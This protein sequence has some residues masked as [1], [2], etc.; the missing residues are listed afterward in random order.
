MERDT[1]PYKSK[2]Q[3]FLLEH[4]TGSKY[5]YA[6]ELQEIIADQVEIGRDANCQVRFDE[7]FETVSRHHA[8]IVR[9]GNHWKLVPLSQTNP[10]FL[11]GEI[12]QKEWY[13]QDGDEIQC[14]VNG[15]KLV[16]KL[17]ENVQLMENVTE[18]VTIQKERH[19]CVTAW[20]VVMIVINS[21]TA[22]IYLFANDFITDSLPGN[23][24]IMIILLGLFGIANIVFAVML[25][26][27]KK[28]GFW[29]FVLSSAA[30]LIINLSIGVG[31]GQSVMGLV[32]I[33][34]LYGI[35]QI[36]KGNTTAWENLE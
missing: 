22:I 9:D 33:F 19:G 8:A 4:K 16:L 24:T 32:G 36:K 15:P 10:T 35:L 21:I 27:W 11:N 7:N 30:V 12:V 20:L 13:L 26:Q 6:G 1:K 18:N 25:L 23:S 2:K 34:I 28:L 17:N 5:H 3:S 31:I 14:A 29:G